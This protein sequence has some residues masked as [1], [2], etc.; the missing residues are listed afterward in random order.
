[1]D[2]QLLE[3]RT[4]SGEGYQPL[5]DYGEWRVAILNY[6]DGIHPQRV[7]TCERHVE[8]DEVFVLLRGQAVLF[9]GEGE[10][11]V[12]VLHSQGMDPGVIYNIKKNVWHTIV[13]SRD[14]S[15]LIVENRDTGK[16][17]SQYSPL[18]PE[19]KRLILETARRAQLDDGD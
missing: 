18:Q 15:V 6:L 19:H 3:I 13:M 16:Q 14:A 17:N 2:E 10:P 1:M 11:Q 8:T 4:Y 5:V 9:L 12:E 7:E